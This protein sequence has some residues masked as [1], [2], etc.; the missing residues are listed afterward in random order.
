MTERIRG[1][2]KTTGLKKIRIGTNKEGRPIYVWSDGD[3]SKKDQLK[4]SNK[5]IG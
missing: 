2:F 5:K 3:I 1:K 4:I